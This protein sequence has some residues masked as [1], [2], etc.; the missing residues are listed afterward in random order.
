MRRIRLH[1]TYRFPL[2]LRC[3]DILMVNLCVQAICEDNKVRYVPRSWHH[4]HT[5]YFYSSSCPPCQLNISTSMWILYLGG[6]TVDGCQVT[7]LATELTILELV[8]TSALKMLF[9]KSPFVNQ[10]WTLMLLRPN[11]DT[12]DLICKALLLSRPALEL[13]VWTWTTQYLHLKVP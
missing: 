1:E 9:H 8:R 10:S 7:K 3:M 13:I 11:Y 5:I 2:G 12:F 4:D 6:W